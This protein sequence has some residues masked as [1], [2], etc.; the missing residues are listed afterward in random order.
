MT[1]GFGLHLS[2]DEIDAWLDATLAPERARHLDLCTECRERADV[3]RELVQQ[4]TSLELLSPAAGFADRVM[5]HVSVPSPQAVR[6][7]QTA[8]RRFLAT[9]RSVA[10]AAVLAVL[11]VGSMA[12]SIVWTLGHQATLASIG[13]WVLAQI[14]QAGWIT[15]QGVASNLIEQPWYEA[16]R[17]LFDSPGRAVAAAL[18]AALAY[19]AG[20]FA[21]R[22]LLALPTQQVAHASA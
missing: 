7:L 19:L 22:R 3:E 12:G 20:I 16:A 2:A 21:L 9:R 11:L 4:L 10:V 15:V 8:R 1:P 17:S 18:L 6:S 14:G 13:G 5:Q